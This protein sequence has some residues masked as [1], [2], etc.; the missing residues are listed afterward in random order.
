MNAELKRK[1]ILNVPYV[2]AG[3]F[4]DKIGWL[5]RVSEGDMVAMK[6]VHAFSHLGDACANPMPS[7]HPIDLLIGVASGL[8]LKFAVYYKGKNANKFRQG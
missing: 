5:V 6:A 1:I 2:I 4:A 8:L 7:F 3:Y